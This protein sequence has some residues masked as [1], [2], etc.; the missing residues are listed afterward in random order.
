[1]IYGHTHPA[2]CHRV[3]DRLII[4][5]GSF[6]AIGRN[7]APGTYALLEVGNVLQATIHEVPQFS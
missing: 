3:G 6:K 1:M 7:V 5:P 2:V 4:N